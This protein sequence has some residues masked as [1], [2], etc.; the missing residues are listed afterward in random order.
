MRI[1]LQCVSIQLLFELD[2]PPMT[3]PVPVE[4]GDGVEVLVIATT[5]VLAGVCVDV[6]ARGSMPFP[7]SEQKPWNHVWSSLLSDSAVHSAVQIESG[8]L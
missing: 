8:V 4:V 5:V 2:A 1:H 6:V 3:L 7:T